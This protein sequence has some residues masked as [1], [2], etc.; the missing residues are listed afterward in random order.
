MTKIFLIV[1]LLFSCECFRCER[2][3]LWRLQLQSLLKDLAWEVCSNIMLA[4]FAQ[5]SCMQS[6][7]KYR[8]FIVYS[9]IF[10]AKF[11]YRSWVSEFVLGGL[12]IKVFLRSSKVEVCL[13]RS[14]VNVFLKIFAFES[15]VTIHSSH[16]ISRL[17]FKGRSSTLNPSEVTVPF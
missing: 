2:E 11:A 10:N 14:N 17:K 9:K 1:T 5:R 15:E 8:E 4:N 3:C 7:F 13:Q 6:L 16:F 12:N